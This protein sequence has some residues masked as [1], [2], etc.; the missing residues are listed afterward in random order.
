ML[1][2]IVAYLLLCGPKINPGITNKC[3]FAGKEHGIEA[4]QIAIN[5]KV[6]FPICK[7]WQGQRIYRKKVQHVISD[8]II[9]IDISLPNSSPADDLPAV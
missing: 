7:C 6:V 4:L 5:F 9:F 2:G 1:N 8:V 3:Q